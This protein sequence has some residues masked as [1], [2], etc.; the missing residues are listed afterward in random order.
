MSINSTAYRLTNVALNLSIWFLMAISLCVFGDIIH[1]S[2][3]AICLIAVIASVLAFAK[4]VAGKKIAAFGLSGVVLL[5]T[6]LTQFGLVVVYF[7]I[8]EENLSD[9]ASWT[10][11]FLKSEN[12]VK[13]VSLGII[14]VCAYMIGIEM[15]TSKSQLMSMR[16]K[17]QG[18]MPQEK[19]YTLKTGYL[20]LLFT[21]IVLLYYIVTGQLSLS[22]TYSEFT[23]LR[24]GNTFWSY[25]I[26]IYATGIAYVVSVGNKAQI[27]KGIILY[28][29]SGTVLF[30]TGNKG[31]VLY[32]A[33]ACV[34]VYQYR[35]NKISLKMV[36]AG[37]LVLFILIPFISE[38]RNE[39][40]VLKSLSTIGLNYTD[41]LTEMGMQIRLSVY[42]LDDFQNG[43]RD[44]LLGYSYI[45]PFVNIIDS[46][47]FNIG[48]RLPVPPSY[49][50]EARFPGY[51]FSQIAESY[52]N[53]GVYGVIGFYLLMGFILSKI[54][55]KEVELSPLKL[56]YF[57]SII[58]ILINATRNR[59]SFVP[60]QILI[61]TFIYFA[62]KILIDS[63]RK[64]IL[65]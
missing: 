36:I 9:I 31:E 8:G 48:I 15:A 14:A 10:L 63:K 46:L 21:L 38:S 44:F 39:G 11:M 4:I 23:S 61:M 16:K 20:M 24:T 40:G 1:A 5:Y 65:Q 2:S 64:R 22:G 32:A 34:G 12:L 62:I 41:S 60:G 29:I 43:T 53:F 35:G 49:N 27:R 37:L 33:L 30:L 18:E 52:C 56:A 50:F 19:N 54:E 28:M 3:T 45:S 42:C 13:G 7:L 55:S 6:A 26:V 25:L 57:T 51:G 58:T 47:L 17:Y 59:F